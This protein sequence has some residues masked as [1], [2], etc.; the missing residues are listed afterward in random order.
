MERNPSLVMASANG[1]LSPLVHTDSTDPS[2]T[3]S[4]KRKRDD[5]VEVENHVNSITDS[6][7]GETAGPSAEESQELI[8][9]LIDVLKM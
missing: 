8:R 9:D 4:A 2:V 1:V 6:K 5:S 3:P 7:N